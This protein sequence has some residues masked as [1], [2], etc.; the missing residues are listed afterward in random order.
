VRQ[1]FRWKTPGRRDYAPVTGGS[2][3]PAKDKDITV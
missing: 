3:M 1:V 2:P